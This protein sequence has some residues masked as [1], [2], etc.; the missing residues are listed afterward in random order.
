MF[1]KTIVNDKDDP[2]FGEE[3]TIETLPACIILASWPFM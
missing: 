3:A 2:K 1:V